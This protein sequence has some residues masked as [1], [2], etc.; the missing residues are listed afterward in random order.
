[1]GRIYRDYRIKMVIDFDKKDLS[2]SLLH[3]ELETP[4]EL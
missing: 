2:I 3:W 4:I 1:M